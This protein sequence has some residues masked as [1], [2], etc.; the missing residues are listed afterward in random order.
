MAEKLQNKHPPMSNGFR[1]PDLRLPV[2]TIHPTL[3]A[4]LYTSSIEHSLR[5]SRHHRTNYDARKTVVRSTVGS[6]A[7]IPTTK[8]S[9]RRT[10]AIR[11]C[12][13][14]HKL[15]A[16]VRKTVTHQCNALATE[17]ATDINTQINRFRVRAQSIWIVFDNQ[18]Q[19][20]RDPFGNECYD[21]NVRTTFPHPSHTC[22]IPQ[23]IHC[24]SKHMQYLFT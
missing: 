12:T 24:M 15:L 10:P 20:R 5:T 14:T 13:H 8:H 18:T 6:F 7:C 16:V 11:H 23:N 3:S 4:Y 9:E 2:H 1:L 21:N 22:H 19:T 17:T